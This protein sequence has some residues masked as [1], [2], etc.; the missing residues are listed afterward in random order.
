V[1]DVIMDDGSTLIIVV[2]VVVTCKY[3]YIY[4]YIKSV[5][6]EL[7]SSEIA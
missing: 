1:L 4:I 7:R 6:H 5:K 2:V 3:I